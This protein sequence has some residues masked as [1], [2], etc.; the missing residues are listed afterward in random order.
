MS[1]RLLGKVTMPRNPRIHTAYPGVYYIEV[2]SQVTG[3][4]NKI[5]YITYRRD[6]K[7]FEERVGG[8]FPD[9]MTPAQAAAIRLEKIRGALPSNAEARRPQ[10]ETLNDLWERFRHD[11]AGL[12]SSRWHEWLYNR[13]IRDAIGALRVSDIT[14]TRI[15]AITRSV[16]ENYAPA[17]VKHVLVMIRRIINHGVSRHLCSPLSFAIPMPRVNNEKTEDVTE[18]QLSRLVA[19]LVS[20]TD[21]DAADLMMI[22]LASGMR[23]AEILRLSWEDVDYERGFIT[24]RESKSGQPETI[25]LNASTRDVLDRRKKCSRW[26]FPSP[27]DSHSHRDPKGL[28]RQVRAICNAAGLPVTIRPVHGLRHVFASIL[29]SSGQVDLYTIQ[30]LLTHKNPSTTKRYAHLRDAALQTASAVMDKALKKADPKARPV[31]E[32]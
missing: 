26:V 20:T 16:G 21:R 6:G 8:Q 24:I 18:E 32:G 1:G 14:P 2:I 4:P 9:R 29:A 27:V 31:G 23:H 30:R 5:F 11:K 15:D 22:A 13:H 28:R 17:T 10:M 12:K 3:K 25:P 7:S 19:I